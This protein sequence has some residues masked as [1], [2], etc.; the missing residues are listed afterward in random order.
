M[1]KDRI[2]EIK[3]EEDAKSHARWQERKEQEAEAAKA[4][5]KEGLRLTTMTQEQIAARIGTTPEKLKELLDS[6]R[7]EEFANMAHEQMMKPI[8]DA[9]KNQTAFIN[10]IRKCN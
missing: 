1:E 8:R 6:V 3:E 9:V 4:E 10:S 2:R 7:C 5:P